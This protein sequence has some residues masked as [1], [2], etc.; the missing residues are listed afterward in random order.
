MDYFAAVLLVS[1][2]LVVMEVRG[3]TGLSEAEKEDILDFHNNLRSN[4]YPTAANMEIMVLPLVISTSIL[5]ATMKIAI[6]SG[7][8]LCIASNAVA[9]DE[10]QTCQN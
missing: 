6:C 9:R 10:S 7:Q 4:V 1:S 2:V 8:M 3:Q 5:Q